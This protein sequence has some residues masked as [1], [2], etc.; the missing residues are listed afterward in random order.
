MLLQFVLLVLWIE[1]ATPWTQTGVA[2]AVLYFID[3][4]AICGLSY[5]EHESTIHPSALLNA[6][7]FCSLLFDIARTR[8]LWLVWEPVSLAGVFTAGVAVKVILLVLETW[9]KTSSFQDGRLG[10]LSP[11]DISGF[12]EKS[13]LTWLIQLLKLG[14]RKVLLVDDLYILPKDMLANE[15]Y[16]RVK[17]AWNRG[18]DLSKKGK[19]DLIKLP[20]SK[21]PKHALVLTIFKCLKW[22]ALAPVPA[23]LAKIALT[24]AQPYLIKRVINLLSSPVT[25]LTTAEGYGLIG[26]YALVFSGLAVCLS[27]SIFTHI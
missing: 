20:A 2:A 4:I 23:R 25:D 15:L 19:P 16:E 5:L 13:L 11:E 21:S 22:E 24:F 7:L 18:I 6:Y 17:K 9:H 1:I 27:L 8:T 3:A 26:A 14:Y 12:Y 10:W